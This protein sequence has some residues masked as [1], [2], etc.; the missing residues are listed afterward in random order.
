MLT[1]D[2]YSLGRQTTKNSTQ[3]K[4]SKLLRDAGTAQRNAELALITTNTVMFK[5]GEGIG[6]FSTNNSFSQKRREKESSSKIQ[7]SD[8]L[9]PIINVQTHK[10]TRVRIKGMELFKHQEEGITFLK[11]KKRAILADEMG[12]G[13][14]MQAIYA[15]GDTSEATIL[16]VCPASLKINWEREIHRVYPEDEIAILS[17]GD[18]EEAKAIISP[19]TAWVII[20][21]DILGK[22]WEWIAEMAHKGDIEAGIFDEAHYAKD[23]KA[24][25]TKAVLAIA[26][27]LKQVYMMT[28]TPVLNR[29]IE[30]FSLLRAIRHP[31]AYSTEKS[32]PKLRREY[33]TRYCD[34]KIRIIYRR[35]GGVLRFWEESGATRLPELR[36]LT[37]DVFLRRTKNEVLDLP[38]KIISVVQCTLSPEDQKDYDTAWE[39]YLDYIAK[40]PLKKDIVNIINAQG[41]VELTKLKQVCS[42][43]KIPRIV[44]DVENAV[45]Q[46]NKVIIFSQYTQTIKDIASAL[47]TKKIGVVTLTGENDMKERQEAVDGFQNKDDIMVFVANIKAGGV[48]ITLT[49]ASQVIFADMDWSPEIH[50]QAED[51]AHRIGQT[52]TVNVYYYVMEKT[53]EEDIVDVLT[54]KQETIGTLTGGDTTIKVFMDLLV[55]RMKGRM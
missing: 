18:I 20:N 53:I 46:G 32:L 40:N 31:L 39:Q 34:G 21:Y 19:T 49:A 10:R 7:E 41:L 52:G 14:T 27:H 9:K 50:R 54:Q 13:K 36:E 4:V 26:E 55:E 42:H 12:L 33:S 35:G 29:P 3:K 24:I 16:V 15:A 51:R 6:T 38:E 1:A 25:R 8:Q 17:G 48:G 11:E 44:S 45:D 5:K 28:G 30:M 2:A 43:S 37:R 23:T 47:R 22:H